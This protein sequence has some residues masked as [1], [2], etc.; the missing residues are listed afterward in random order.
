V[1]RHAHLPLLL[2][3]DRTKMSKRMGD[4]AAEAYR[5]QGYLPDALVNFLALLG[6][7]PPTDQE[8]FTREELL[9]HFSVERI[10]KSGAVFDRDKL[11]WMNQVYIGRMEPDALFEALRPFLAR[12]PY[13]GQDGAR[14]RQAVAV[15]QPKLVTLADIGEHLGVFFRPDDAPLDPAV[16]DA[17]AQADAQTVFA[18]MRTHLQGVERLDKPAFSALMKAVQKETG[19]KGK[20]LWGP[21]RAAITLEAEG[22][23]LAGVVEVLGRDTVLARIERALAA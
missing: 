7:H 8:L 17:I 6:W 23:D 19:V 20:Q 3:P 14:L 12:T 11:N 2:N 21:V 13:A 1:P 15:V 16:R 9:E 10:V 18:T 22:P 5:D 4:T